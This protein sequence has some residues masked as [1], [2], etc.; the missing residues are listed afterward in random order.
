VQPPRAK[1][2]A[3]EQLY[4]VPSKQFEDRTTYHLSY[5]NVDRV[6]ARYARLQPIRPIHSL[7]K[8]TGKFFD[9]TTYKLCYRPIWQTV[10]A[11]PIIPKRR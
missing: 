10:K 3:P 7:E 4:K 5:L 1:S 2:F 6:A 8:S 11:K 9:E